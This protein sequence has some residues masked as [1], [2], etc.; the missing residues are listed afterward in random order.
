MVSLQVSCW[1]HGWDTVRLCPQLWAVFCPLPGL[2]WVVIFS[3]DFSACILGLGTTFSQTKKMLLL[4]NTGHLGLSSFSIRGLLKPGGLIQMHFVSW[5]SGLCFP[6]LL[7]SHL[8]ENH[9]KEDHRG[10][11]DSL[12]IPKHSYKRAQKQ[13]AK[14]DWCHSFSFSGTCSSLNPKGF[15]GYNSFQFALFPV[16]YHQQTCWGAVCPIIQVV[17]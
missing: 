12:L 15:L 7:R 10:T 6:E 3:N 11:A 9:L 5:G 13:D 16:F 1:M 17:S 8:S 4:A 2:C 14:L